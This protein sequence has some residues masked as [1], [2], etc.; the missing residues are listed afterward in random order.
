MPMAE[1][2]GNS[3]E[4]V[5]DLFNITTAVDDIK[6]SKFSQFVNGEKNVTEIPLIAYKYAADKNLNAALKKDLISLGSKT[7]ELTLFAYGIRNLSGVSALLQVEVT[8]QNVARLVLGSADLMTVGLG[9]ICESS[10]SEFCKAYKEYELI[11]NLGLLSANVLNELPAIY[12]GLKKGLDDPLLNQTQKNALREVLEEGAQESV[13]IWKLGLQN[14]GKPASGTTLG[15]NL[16]AFGKAR[17]AN[18]HAHH[19]TAGGASNLDAQRARQIL[20]NEGIDINEAANGVFLPSSSKYAIDNAVP[21]ANVHT[22]VYY[23]EVYDRLK[24]AQPGKVR[25]ELQKIADELLNGT[26]PY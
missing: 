5:K 6:F 20:Q 13:S 24:V 7:I 1:A 4:A 15:E 10:N 23:R 8:A 22:N 18:S 25:D 19:I 12:N 17:P 16:I 3:A 26:F 14:L 21:H 11:I 2:G 9:R